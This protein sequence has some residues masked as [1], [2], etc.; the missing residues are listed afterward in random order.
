MVTSQNLNDMNEI[1]NTKKPTRFYNDRGK[2]DIILIMKKVLFENKDV[3]LCECNYAWD[4]ERIEANGEA[5]GGESLT[6]GDKKE[7]ITILFEKDGGTVLHKDFD[8]WYAEN[9]KPKK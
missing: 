4:F 2:T 3:C 8:P 5:F 1:I 7:I 9:Y 6:E